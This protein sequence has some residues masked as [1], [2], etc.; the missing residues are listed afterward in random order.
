MEGVPVDQAADWL[1]TD[2]RTLRRVYRKFDPTY[3]RSVAGALDL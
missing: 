3:L 2:P 1:E